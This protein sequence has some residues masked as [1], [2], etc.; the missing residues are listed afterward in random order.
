MFVGALLVVR[1]WSLSIWV[2][3]AVTLI[4]AALTRLQFMVLTST[5][6]TI[7]ES[8]VVWVDQFGKQVGLGRL[9][10]LTLLESGAPF[11][12][13]PTLR[14]PNGE[15]KQVFALTTFGFAFDSSAFDRFKELHL[16]ASYAPDEAPEP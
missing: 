8:D 12:N 16:A 13:V 5:S 9:C 1:S 3:L 4:L 15:T 2:A 7:D 10:D 14:K 6:V 11:P